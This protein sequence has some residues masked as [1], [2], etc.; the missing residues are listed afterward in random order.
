MCFGWSVENGPFPKIFACRRLDTQQI[1]SH[2]NHE[3]L[4]ASGT[5][6]GSGIDVPSGPQDSTGLSVDSDDSK[7]LFEKRDYPRASYWKRAQVSPDNTETFF[8]NPHV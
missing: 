4:P 6:L 1:G 2:R 5:H 8:P 7:A 3:T